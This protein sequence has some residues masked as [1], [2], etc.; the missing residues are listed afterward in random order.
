[1]DLK[2]PVQ[3]IAD[4]I[5][6]YCRRN[7][8][9]LQDKTRKTERKKVNVHYWRKNKRGGQE[10]NLGDYLSLVLVEEMKQHL[11]I[12]DEK[13][14]KKTKHLY[15]IGSILQ[16]GYQNATVWGS[17]FLDNPLGGKFGYISHG[18]V[19]RKLDV[20]AVRG[21]L[22][23]DVLLKLGHECP[24]I[25]GDPAILMPL[26]YQPKK[27][28]KTSPYVVVRHYLDKEKQENDINILTT[29]DQAFIDALYSSERVISSSLHGIILAES[30]GIPAVLYLPQATEGDLTLYKYK[31]YYFGTGRTEFPVATTIE[32]ALA[33]KPCPI[34]DMT[35]LRENLLRAFPADLWK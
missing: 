2:N 21:P 34:P 25:Y 24:E 17:G 8:V 5:P 11:S 33:A 32:E 19:L 12:D 31:D 35:K 30:Y 10:D 3:T 4:F 20:R 16:A 18:S 15:A 27:L 1:M 6:Q 7:K 9:I 22:T 13:K 26:F 14:L 28:D 29:D 23:R